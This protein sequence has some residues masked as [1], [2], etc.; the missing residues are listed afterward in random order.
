M[1][2]DT[3]QQLQGEVGEHRAFGGFAAGPA[4][5]QE[6]PHAPEGIGDGGFGSFKQSQARQYLRRN[7]VQHEGQDKETG[8]F[9]V[10]HGVI[11]QN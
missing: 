11:F 2:H 5:D 7:V 8:N 4:K 9:S 3:D 1:Q 10:F 6:Q